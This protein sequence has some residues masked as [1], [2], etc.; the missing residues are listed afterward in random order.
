MP[1]FERLVVHPSNPAEHRVLSGRVRADFAG[2]GGRCNTPP[3]D[4]SGSVAPSHRRRAIRRSALLGAV[5]LATLASCS[6][7][8]TSSTS[9]SRPASGSSTSATTCH[10]PPARTIRATPVT[11]TPTDWT[12]TSF[13][14]TAIRAHWFPHS[15]FAP[16][17][18]A[19][20]H[21]TVL[22]GPGWS[23]SGDTNTNGQGILGAVPIRSLLDAGYNVLTWDPRG[24][25]KS[26]G[27]AEVDSALYEARD[28]STLIGWVSTKPGVQLDAPGDPRMGMV[29]GSYGG[30]IQIVTAATDCRVDAIV[31]TIA[32]HSLTTSLDKS[33]TIKSGW[34]GILSNLSG[35]DH[36]D[37][38]VSASAASGSTTGT[39]T[40][41]QAAWF[42]ARGPAHLVHRI[43]VP[44][45]I[46]QGT[47]DTLFTLQEGVDNYKVL[48]AAGTTSAMQWFCGG[49]GVCLTDPGDTA[50]VEQATLAWLKRYVQRDTSVDT[51]PGFSFVDQNGTMYSAPSYPPTQGLPF[52]ANGS[53]TLALV[54]TGGSGPLTATPDGQQL[55][56]L[57]APITP[58][59]ATNA[60]DVPVVFPSSGVI[61]GAPRVL[62]AYKGTTPAHDRPTRVFAQLVDTGT[63]LVLGNQ[64]T[65]IAVTLDG[66]THTVSIPLEIVAYTATASSHVQLQLVATTVAY[67]PPQLGG[68]ITF[69]TIHV[70]LP[71]AASLTPK[72]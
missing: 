19:G 20:P 3:M 48:Q 58:A 39:I 29:G 22:M 6:S 41:A 21:P 70:T 71:V 27:K 24:F 63:G 8:S 66:H 59:P 52:A 64:V 28:V 17:S 33:G 12:V 57:V 38:V 9:T 43:T 49:H 4:T 55:A 26:G 32:W 61:V 40:P 23:L 15:V 53:G 35:G 68:S 51:G 5:L 1:P 54:S 11:G 16:G 67:A 72:S 18:G 10:R 13:D 25:G 45:L 7:S 37:P 62:L 60:V 2:E 56:A 46:V 30:G 14:K 42:A 44:T 47:V 31:P 65:P 69:S 50:A 36:V 34:S